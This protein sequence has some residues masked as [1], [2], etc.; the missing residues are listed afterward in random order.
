MGRI[1]EIILNSLFM[2]SAY[3][4]NFRVRS[5]NDDSTVSF[6]IAY[7]FFSIISTGVKWTPVLRR[8]HAHFHATIFEKLRVHVHVHATIFKKFVSAPG[9]RKV[10]STSAR[11]FSISQLQSGRS[12][13]LKVNGLVSQSERSWV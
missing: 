13:G 12:K 10:V 1:S 5:C 3:A 9:F 11:G 8:A 6:Y 2:S 7:E 4:D